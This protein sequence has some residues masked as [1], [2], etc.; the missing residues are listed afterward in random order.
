MNKSLLTLALAAIVLTGAGTQASAQAPAD[1][2]AGRFSVADGKQVYFAKGNLQYTQSTQTWSFAE[3]QYDM[4]GEANVS[5]GALADK[6][7]MFGWSGSTGSAKWGI[8]TSQSY[9]DY[10]GDF[11]DWGTNIGDGSTWYTLDVAEWAYLLKYRT[12]AKNLMGVARINLNAD[13]SQY[14]NG[15]VLLPDSWVCPAGVTFKSGFANKEGVQAYANYQILTLS[16]WQKLESSGAVF[17]PASSIRIGA[18]VINIQSNGYYWSATPNGAS[19]A[20][21]QYTTSRQAGT[22]CNNN[23]YVGHTVR[24]VKNCATEEEAESAYVPKPFTVAQG[25]QITFSG[26]NLQYTQST[27]T[28]AF[29]EHQYDMFGDANVSGSALA[30]KIDLFGWSGSMGSAKWGI[31]TSQSNSAYS[32]DFVDWGTNTIGTDAPNTWRTLTHDEWDYLLKKRLDAAQFNG[33]A[34]IQFGENKYANGLVLLPDNWICPAGVTFKSGFAGEWSV[35]AYADYQTF[36][37]TDWLEL[38]ASGAVFLPAS[39]YRNESLMSFEPCVNDVQSYGH[40]WSA[41]PDDSYIACYLYF[42]SSAAGTN[43]NY[44]NYG[45]S[46]RLVKNYSNVSTDLS[47]PSAADTAPARKLLRNG[48][49]LIERNGKTYTLTGVEVK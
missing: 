45:R 11:V 19:Y 48:Q 21:Y 39:G 46:V 8:S 29:A 18:D 43:C 35:Q 41:T 30:D 10:S 42:N 25:K 24:L 3:H 33:V 31:S 2:I 40:Y 37:L 22:G 1:A 23:R 13:G 17:L 6:I 28:W 34:R 16:D 14:A 4:I 5:N 9:S 15:L 32:G 12:N 7:D 26:G 44:R 38:E 47:H 36:T 49:V 27:Q 20:N